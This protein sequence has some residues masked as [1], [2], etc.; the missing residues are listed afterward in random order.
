[1]PC[2]PSNRQLTQNFQNSTLFSNRC[3]AIRLE[4]KWYF[5]LHFS[6][7]PTVDKQNKKKGKKPIRLLS[8]AL[9]FGFS[10]ADDRLIGTRLNL[11]FEQFIEKRQKAKLHT[12]TFAKNEQQPKKTIPICI[13]HFDENANVPLT[14]LRKH[15][16]IRCGPLSVPRPSRKVAK[17]ASIV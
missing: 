5:S 1:M 16:S 13:F 3:F 2:F 12:K 7:A 11:I 17:Q 9:W 15:Y 8:C 4:S 14:L 6:T 10:E